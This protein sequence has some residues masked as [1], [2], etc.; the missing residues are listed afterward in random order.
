MIITRG[1]AKGYGQYAIQVR[2]HFNRGHLRFLSNAD[3]GNQNYPSPR[4][5]TWKTWK[6]LSKLH[7]VISKHHT[8]RV[9]L[10]PFNDSIK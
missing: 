2:N 8:L 5:T 10:L 6:F 9:K 1:K 7:F 4:L 3:D